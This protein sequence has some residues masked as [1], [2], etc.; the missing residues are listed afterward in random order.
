MEQVILIIFYLVTLFFSI[1]LHEISHGVM[2]MWLGDHTARLAGRLSLDPIRH[3]DPIGTI[4]LPLA[5]FFTTGFVFGWA[6]PVPYNPYALRGGKW[7]EVMVAFAGPITNFSLALIASIL[8][9][10]IPF[11]KKKDVILTL[12][13]DSSVDWDNIAGLV[14]GDPMAIIFSICIMFIYWNV[15]LGVFNL[16][17]IPPLDGSKLLFYFI[18]I[19]LKTRVLLETWGF[20]IIIIILRISIFA[21][22]FSSILW[23][24][25]SFFFNITTLL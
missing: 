11:A 5:M 23:F 22:I 1:I 14:S 19:D 18:D 10:A 4:I 7:G 17:P 21:T 15:L 16:I 8:G 12:V 20:F 13:F 3:I 25:W 2:A 9:M 24:L 6:K